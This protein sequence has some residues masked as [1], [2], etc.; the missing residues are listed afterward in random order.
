M[1]QK[2]NSWIVAFLGPPLIVIGFVTKLLYSVF[3]AR[4]DRRSA[5]QREAAF[6]R[7]IETS[8]P[9]LFSDYSA[10]FIPNEGFPFPP[11]FDYVVATVDA[12]AFLL[13]FIHGRGELDVRVAPKN[14]PTKW[15]DLSVVIGIGEE[16]DDLRPRTFFS[17]A[18]A[19]LALKQNLSLIQAAFSHDRYAET[20]RTL[21]NFDSYQRAVAKQ[22]EN[23]INRRLYS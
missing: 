8:L 1:A 23:E 13:R 21:D 20:A 14:T 6:K 11:P 17:L 9:F 22:L 19:A 15:H 18:E 10:Q 5:I 3:F 12:G 7:E 16:R 2:M 4:A